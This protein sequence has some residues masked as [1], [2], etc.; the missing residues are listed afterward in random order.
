MISLAQKPFGIHIAQRKVRR[1]L[2]LAWGAGMLASLYIF[3]TF[4]NVSSLG[5]LITVQSLLGGVRTGGLVR[6][7]T[8]VRHNGTKF[9]TLL[10]TET[11]LAEE[12]PLDERETRRRD[13]VHFRAYTLTRWLGLLLLAGYCVLESQNAV[14][15]PRVRLFFFLLLTIA[16]WTLPQLLILWTEPDMEEEA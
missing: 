13:Q 4:R 1:A 8:P 14:W 7:F 3:L 16:L 11:P 6:P 15:L 12:A 2:V 10:L 9:Q 5:M